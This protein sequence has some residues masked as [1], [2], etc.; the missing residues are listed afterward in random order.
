V[1]DAFMMEKNFWQSKTLAEM[2]GQ[3][4]EALCDGCGLCCLVK[5]EDEDTGDI[6][7]TSVACR[8][9]DI[10]HCRCSDYQHRFEKAPMCTAITADTVADMNWLP[11]TCAYR[12]L[13][14]RQPLPDWHHLIT[15]DKNSV[16]EAGISARWF[17]I[18]EGYVHPDQLEDFI[19]QKGDDSKDSS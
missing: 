1:A 18:S 12:R 6:Y 7:N 4:W 8:L 10:D 15:G 13:F 17:A 9:L 16:H 19:I 3:E 14:F 2:S 11:E 5:L